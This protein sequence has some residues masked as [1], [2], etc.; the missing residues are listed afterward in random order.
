MLRQVVF[1]VVFVNMSFN[2]RDKKSQM[3]STIY[4][5]IVNKIIPCS[6]EFQ[7]LVRKKIAIL[8]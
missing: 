2:C 8:S 7:E 3:D 1:L 4:E 5:K 6:L